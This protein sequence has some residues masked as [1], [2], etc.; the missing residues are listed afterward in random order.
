MRYHPTM[1]VALASLV[2]P[3]TLAAQELCTGPG[4]L[5]GVTSYQCTS[6][7]VEQQPDA[8]TLW[9][10]HAEPLILAV[11]RGSTLRVG[12]VVEAVDGKP[13]TTVEGSALFAYPEVGERR[14]TVRR[15]GS[16]VELRARVPR[17]CTMP[18]QTDSAS[19]GPARQVDTFPTAEPAGKAKT[20]RFGFAVACVPSC[21]RQRLS[22]GQ[23]YWT[24]DGYPPVVAVDA[25][26]PA[27]RGGLRV[28]DVV[29]AV[30]GVS[31]LETEAAL[32]LMRSDRATALRLTVRR[33][34]G[35]SAE[36]RLRAG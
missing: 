31:I 2:S 12:D 25:D 17:S 14:V 34:D 8:R 9:I 30:N 32:A 26:S 23:D 36:V 1:L 27:A 22:D 29:T 4:A 3:L 10:F 19:L 28:G 6:C 21:T 5:F 7:A 24:F 11:G 13:I 33:S 35:K 20:N 16:R 15:G 18:K